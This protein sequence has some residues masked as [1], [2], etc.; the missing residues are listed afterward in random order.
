[1]FLGGLLFLG[2]PAAGQPGAERKLRCVSGAGGTGK[3]RERIGMFP[4]TSPHCRCV[5]R[6]TPLICCRDK[7]RR[8]GTWCEEVNPVLFSTFS[9]SS[10]RTRD[11]SEGS[12]N[13]GRKGV[14][15]QEAVLTQHFTAVPCHCLHKQVLRQTPAWTNN[16]MEPFLGCT[17]PG[18]L[19]GPGE[20]Q[21]R[22]PSAERYLAL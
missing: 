10:K 16:H 22:E 19:P 15:E 9:P 14:R 5:F 4:P 13:Q 12:W 17:G 2:G 3:P 6:Y 8:V 21:V 20:A 18:P 11:G 7:R 1:M